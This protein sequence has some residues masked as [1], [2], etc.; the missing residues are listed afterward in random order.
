MQSNTDYNPYASSKCKNFLPLMLTAESFLKSQVP[1]LFQSIP[2]FTKPEILH[3]AHNS[4]PSLVPILSH[5]NTVHTRPP[6]Y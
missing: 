6:K 1:Q 3:H 2:T 5:M 4:L